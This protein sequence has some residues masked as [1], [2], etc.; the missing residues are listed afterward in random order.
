M[1]DSA[2][3]DKIHNCFHVIPHKS[4]QET[5]K[6]MRGL[7]PRAVKKLAQETHRLGHNPLHDELRGGGG[8]KGESVAGD[9][10]RIVDLTGGILGLGR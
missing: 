5:P 7:L 2:I 9:G 10:R 1:E 6:E 3:S 4:K 8:G